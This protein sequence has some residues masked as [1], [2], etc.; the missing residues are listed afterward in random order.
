[1]SCRLILFGLGLLFPAALQS[2]VL[3]VAISNFATANFQ[4]LAGEEMEA[5]CYDGTN[6]YAASH[7]KILKFADDANWNSGTGVTL[8]GSN[9][10]ALHGLPGGVNHIDSAK[11]WNGYIYALVED[12]Q[13]PSQYSSR[14]FVRYDPNSLNWVDY[15]PFAGF[16]NSAMA[17]VP[18]V[19]LNGII[20]VGNYN[21]GT[22]Q[23][24]QLFVFDLL[25]YQPLGIISLSSPIN[26]VQGIDYNPV[27]GRLYICGNG[28]AWGGDIHVVG[29]DGTNYGLIWRMPGNGTGPG[30]EI[31]I[32]SN[33]IRLLYDENNTGQARIIYLGLN[34]P[35][36][37]QG[38]S[39]PATLRYAQ[40]S[41]LETYA[42][43]DTG[44]QQGYAWDGT[45]HYL[46]DSAQIFKRAND[47]NWTVLAS[48]TNVFSG[49]PG[50]NH[51]GDGDYYNGEL[52]IPCEFWLGACTNVSDQ[53][54]VT[55]DA[56]KLQPLKVYDVSA[57]NHEMSGLC[58]VPSDGSN[59]VI[60]VTAYC[61]GSQ[62]W[63]YDLAT[64]KLLGTIPL[65]Q[66][67]Y[68]LRGIAWHDG[69]F[70][71][72][73]DFAQGSVYSMEYNGKI[74]LVCTTP[75]TGSQGGLK[76]TGNVL[77]WLIDQGPGSREVHYISD[78]ALF[79]SWPTSAGSR[80]LQ[81]ASLRGPWS[82]VPAGVFA[83]NSASM[84]LT[85]PLPIAPGTFYLL[86]KP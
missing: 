86:S 77:R 81:S 15:H 30:Q 19:G 83:S 62:V 80:I 78:H 44:C 11:Y 56:A 68:C 52:Y 85:I 84:S 61:D 45:N 23:Q 17:L 35:S 39:P 57:D 25:N 8:I 42:S 10:S 5:Y 40:A 46:I 49:L 28:V 75:V 70:Y 26:E 63:R 41:F 55:F 13:S 58:I 14:M 60:Y 6:H 29:L 16:G 76:Y 21:L 47:S 43:P 2:A 65:S 7:T 3:P 73:E 51:M 53:S 66:T 33:T 9:M 82:S 74:K 37:A 38:G 50:L 64:M 48:N 36:A 24:S 12:W 59:G 1:L 22:P 18:G 67:L 20:V 72:A 32:V 71:L 79:F 54:I 31:N 69:T 27:D 34:F 4:S